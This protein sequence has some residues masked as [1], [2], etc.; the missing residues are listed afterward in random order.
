MIQT[1][2]NI[3]LSEIH[4]VIKSVWNKEK[5]HSIGRNLLLYLFIK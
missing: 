2:G 5:W 1:G 4:K 3:S